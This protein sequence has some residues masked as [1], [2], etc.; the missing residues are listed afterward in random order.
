MMSNIKFKLSLLIDKLLTGPFVLQLLALVVLTI[1]IIFLGTS[2]LLLAGVELTESIWWSFLRMTDFSN[3]MADE[4][5]LNQ[6]LGSFI[7]ILGWVLFGLLISFIA[8]GIQQRIQIIQKGTG[9]VS[10]KNHTVI[11]GW[12][13]NIFSI[14]DEYVTEKND[15]EPPIVVMS[16]NNAEQMYQKIKSFCHTTTHDDVICRYGNPD[17]IEDQNKINIADAKEIIVLN[18]IF[19]SSEV[20]F[21]DTDATTLKTVLAYSKNTENITTKKKNEPNVTNLIID[22]LQPISE[23]LMEG[24]LP[25]FEDR[26]RKIKVST[27][28]SHQIL[29]RI[30]AQCSFQ[31]G[32]S[33]IYMDLFSFEDIDEFDCNEEI[34]S[35]DMQQA[36]IEKPISFQDLYLKFPDA[37]PFGYI[38]KGSENPI[39]NPFYESSEAKRK[40][41]PEE[42]ILFFIAEDLD[43]INFK[44]NSF[45]KIESEPTI[46][47]PRDYMDSLN[48][49]VY[50]GGFKASE[51]VKEL[52]DYLPEGSE[53]FC[54]EK[55]KKY[56]SIE[57]DKE[58]LSFWQMEDVNYFISHATEKKVSQFDIIIM[59]QDAKNP[60][61][62]DSVSLMKLSWLLSSCEENRPRIVMDLLDT[63]SAELA[64]TA[65]ADDV[66]I[67]TEMVSNFLF[68]IARDYNRYL[69]FK[70]LLS[71]RG[72][73]IYFKP[74]SLYISD[75]RKFIFNEVAQIVRK[76]DE[77]LLGY[78]WKEKEGTV[79]WRLNPK[80]EKRKKVIKNVEKVIVVAEEN[81]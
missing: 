17:S 5:P 2:V 41:K 28:P 39:I 42:H 25:T 79:K 74:L 47:E 50:G 63:N 53:I 20:D 43:S 71:S 18:N 3:L 48:I 70:E 54:S 34:Y 16:L 27:V 35:L 45:N 6:I 8:S 19:Q 55:L 76:R 73:E 9:G 75:E 37:L 32:L 72:A 60:M 51:V 46:P 65:R 7:A 56:L 12:N 68:Q 36:G 66:I 57:I 81:D 80:R 58:W 22:I 13:Q 4:E 62:H 1:I 33:Q 24:I 49:L 29:G 23:K 21:L 11:L 69:I 31:P 52:E 15:N 10:L 67:G 30:L 77:I 44:N 26:P 61:R 59:A 40:L 14:L 38:K 64:K 78:S